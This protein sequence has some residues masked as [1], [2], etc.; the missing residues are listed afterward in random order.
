MGIAGNKAGFTAF[1]LAADTPAL[2]RKVAMEAPSG[3]LDF[4]RFVGSAEARCDN[5]PAR[6]LDGALLPGRGRFRRGRN[7]EG[8][9]PCGFGPML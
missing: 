2:F 8:A 4:A 9:R 3:Q 7:E 6:E 5:S 1:A